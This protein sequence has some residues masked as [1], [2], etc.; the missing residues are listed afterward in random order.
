MKNYLLLVPFLLLTSVLKA[1]NPE[2]KTSNS[3][4]LEKLHWIIE[5]S[6]MNTVRAKF[7]EI[8]NDNNFPSIVSSL[9]DGNY[10]GETPFDDYGYKHSVIFEMKKGRIVSIDYDEIHRD[11]HAKQHDEEYC[12][13][14][15]QSGTT[16]A[17]AYPKYESGMLV[18]QDFNQIDAVSGASYSLYRFKL[19]V[20]YAMLNS[21]QL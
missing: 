2:P 7:Q 6:D 3:V 9:K 18:K 4:V 16:P 11:G 17:I 13:N 14:M 19:A 15:L 1:Q 12:K 21:G 20:L 5:R 10:K 8:C